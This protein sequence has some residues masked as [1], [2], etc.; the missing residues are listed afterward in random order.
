MIYYSAVPLPRDGLGN[1]KRGF[2]NFDQSLQQGLEAQLFAGHNLASLVGQKSHQCVPEDN[3]L[4]RNIRDK[5]STAWMVQFQSKFDGTYHATAR[6]RERGLTAASGAYT[7]KW[8]WMDWHAVQL[9]Q[10]NKW[11]EMYVKL[12]RRIRFLCLPVDPTDAPPVNK[13]ERVMKSRGYFQSSC[14]C[15]S[16]K[17]CS[18]DEATSRLAQAT[19][20]WDRSRPYRSNRSRSLP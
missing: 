19:Y 9:V 16:I 6:L 10:Q 1:F 20:R 7:Q 8:V 2:S 17:A 11:I 13:P 4:P 3:A 14:L 12:F 18:T 15:Y 5:T